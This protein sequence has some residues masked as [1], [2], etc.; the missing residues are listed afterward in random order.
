MAH[1]AEKA[2]RAKRRIRLWHV[3]LV[4]VVALVAVVLVVRGHWKRQL[5]RRIEALAAAGYPVTPEELDASY[6]WPQS[7]ENGA[8]WVIGASTY[9]LELPKEDH[10]ALR[11]IL[12]WPNRSGVRALPDDVRDLLV[13]HI[14]TNA[15]A[16]EL[17]HHCAAIEESRYPIDL[18]EGLMTLLPSVGDVRQC[19][20]LLCFQAV[21]CV[22]QG[23]PDGAI[24]AIEA[25]IGVARTL[26]REPAFISQ[27]VYMAMTHFTTAT[28]ERLL[29]QCQ[30]TDAQLDR[31]TQAVSRAYEPGAALRGLVGIQCLNLE[32]FMRPASIDPDGFH[33]F[34]PEAVVDLYSALGLA[35]REGVVYLDLMAQCLAAAQ[36][37]TSER[38]Q[39]SVAIAT[40]YNE[41]SKS[42][43]LLRN[44][45]VPWYLLK[46]EVRS[47]ACVRCAQVGLAVERYRLSQGRLPESL[48]GLVPEYLD[49]VP[50]D[51]YDGAALR[52]KQLE[53]GFVVYSVGE[54][55]VD[56][57]GKD[58]P[59]RGDGKPDETYDITFVVAR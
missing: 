43:V 58:K 56:E 57:G 29:C 45:S 49:R 55:G 21:L 9:F 47:L 52:Y 23:D 19:C 10:L 44:A 25:A 34:P 48:V 32:L 20:L 3:L 36:Q 31:V 46:Q 24:D 59:P 33:E 17:L 51:P 5:H 38:C 12:S 27:V 16:L 37:P 41:L 35:A 18:S 1:E 30:L 8:D 26:R 50:E 14:Q 13:Q 53:R 22:E 15:K 6:T 42:S 4:L 2:K 54:D 7:D 39:A 40:R 11:D 28:A